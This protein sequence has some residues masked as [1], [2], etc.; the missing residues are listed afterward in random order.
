MIVVWPGGARPR[1][2]VANCSPERSCE[3]GCGL[4]LWPQ[5]CRAAANCSLHSRP[6]K[7]Y[8]STRCL[9]RVYLCT[10]DSMHECA[11]RKQRLRFEEACTIQLCLRTGKN[12]T[13]NVNIGWVL[14]G[15]RSVPVC[16]ARLFV[17][18]WQP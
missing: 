7:L 2:R 13:V 12:V 10:S 17:W 16:H 5:G 4:G 9:S 3:L 14:R 11:L 15:M 18:L 1:M 8:S 6:L